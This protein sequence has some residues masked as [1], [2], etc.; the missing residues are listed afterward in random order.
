[1]L[2]TLLGIGYPASWR[3]T[4]RLVR[5]IPLPTV[6][7]ALS[8][9]PQLVGSS[10][11]LPTVTYR[12][13]PLPTVTYR[14]L[15]L[16]EL[17]HI[18]LNSFLTFVDDCEIVDSSSKCATAGDWDALVGCVGTPCCGAGTVSRRTSTS[19]SYRYIPCRSALDTVAYRYVPLR[20]RYCQPKDID[21]LFILVNSPTIG[22]EKEEKYNKKRMLNRQVRNRM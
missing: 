19:S 12:Y 10:R 1:M 13:L 18:N 15:P 14:Y 4:A 2:S 9:Q 11:P 7:G 21:Q 3:S 5:Y 20:R 17:F 16:Q 8:H 22:M 6:T